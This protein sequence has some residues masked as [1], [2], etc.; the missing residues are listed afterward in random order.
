MPLPRPRKDES[1]GDFMI[2]CMS[3]TYM[4]EKY[5]RSNQR[6]AVCYTQWEKK[7]G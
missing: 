3:N 7:K 4:K 1:K 6:A 5:P 2:R